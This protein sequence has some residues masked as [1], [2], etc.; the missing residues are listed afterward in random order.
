MYLSFP[1]TEAAPWLWIVLVAMHWRFSPS[2]TSFLKMGG[3]ELNTIIKV[4]KNHEWI[5][6]HN[7][8]FCFLLYSFPNIS[9][10]FLFTLLLNS[11]LT[12]W[13]SSRFHS[14]VVM[15]SQNSTF[16]MLSQN[17]FSLYVLL[18]IY[19][20]ISYLTHKWNLRIDRNISHST[21]VN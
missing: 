7:D 15:V 6:F 17:Y 10:S 11:K 19:P 1:C 12:I 3:P 18:Y 2:R 20:C 9:I 16:Y 14:W 21:K 8:V 4:W 13:W 5:C